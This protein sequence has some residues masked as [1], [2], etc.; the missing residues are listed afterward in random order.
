M[1]HV[2]AVCSANPGPNMR[3]AQHAFGQCQMLIAGL[4]HPEY[5]SPERHELSK[6]FYELYQKGA[7][8]DEVRKLVAEDPLHFASLIFLGLSQ[9]AL[10]AFS[11]DALAE[12]HKDV[13]ALV[14]GLRRAG[15]KVDPN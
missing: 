14:D 3:K 7:P 2:D 15:D 13:D 4:T 5:S 10:L 1:S 6:R 8:P 9:I 12:A 11:A